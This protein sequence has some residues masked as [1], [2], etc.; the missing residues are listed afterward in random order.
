[1]KILNANG[2]RVCDIEDDGTIVIVD[3]GCTTR[4]KVFPDGRHEVENI[5]APNKVA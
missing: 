3:R 1:M 4:I 2:K 5:P